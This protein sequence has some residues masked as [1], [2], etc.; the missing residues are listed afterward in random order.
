[1]PVTA[2][3]TFQFFWHEHSVSKQ[4]RAG[5]S[6]HSHT[7]YSE[8][9]LDMVPRYTARV[10][11]L[12]SAIRREE[13]KYSA[14]NAKDFDFGH[15]FWTP[16]LAPRQAYRLEEKQIQRKFE[17]PA[18]VSLTD[19]DDIQAGTLLRVLDRFRKAPI[20]TEWTIPF[21]PTFFHLGV[22]NLPAGEA[23]A[24]MDRLARYTAG[25][26]TDSLGELLHVLNGYADVLL[27]LNH[28][29]WDEKG[30]GAAEHEQLLFRLI[31]EH[32]KFFHALELNGLRSWRENRQVIRLGR[33]SNLP[34]IS[35]GDRHGREPNAILNLARSATFVEFIQEV[36]YEGFS[37]VVFMPQYHEPLKLR[38]LQTMVDVVRDYPEN[39][40]GRRT[41]A[42]RVFY[43]DPITG[44][45]SPISQIWNDGGPRIVKHFI[46]AMRL[47]E[48]R[49][50][51]SAL[52]IA[53]D[54]KATVWS[55][56]QA[57]L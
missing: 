23:G 5:V 48:W 2:Q 39:A 4:F 21:G 20:S 41:W 54:D 7:M 18:L 35:G 14:R 29:Y 45:P 16:P 34:L 15:A 22:H 13:A 27:V 6:L 38:V 28:P 40:P 17:L 26:A 12:G 47:L 37:H 43:R 24:I 25:E 53:L 9:S 42:D 8:E 1:M 31:Q 50:V 49:G 10:P 46:A 32:G 33:E 3:T 56:Q 36:R 44:A 55:D 30:I 19:H 11:Y 57:A 52:R 51:R